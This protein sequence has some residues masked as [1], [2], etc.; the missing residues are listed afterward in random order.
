VRVL[1]DTAF[2]VRLCWVLALFAL[3]LL[4]LVWRL[5][6][7]QWLQRDFLLEEGKNRSIRYQSIPA[8]RGMIVDRNGVPLAVSSVLI[9]LQ[10]GIDLWAEPRPLKKDEKRRLRNLAKVLGYEPDAF[11]QRVE[12]EG[13]RARWAELA[14][15]LGEPVEVLRRRLENVGQAN[16]VDGETEQDF[17]QRV[18]NVGTRNAYP[19]VRRLAPE[20]AKAVLALKIPGIV[21]KEEYRRYYP[22]GEM[23]TQLIGRINHQQQAKEGLELMFDS[24]LSG[25]EGKRR[26][27]QDKNGRL[28]KELEVVQ[29]A[30]PGKDLQLSIDMRLQ[31]LANHALVG[32]LERSKASWGTAVL[33]DVATGEILALANQPT[34]NPNDPKSYQPGPARNHALLDNLQP[35][36]TVKPLSML[37]ALQSGRWKPEDTV[38]L[39]NRTLMVKGRK[40]PIRDVAIGGPNQPNLTQILIESSNVG[41]SKIALDIGP[42]PIREVM[43]QMGFGQ[44]SGLEFPREQV[45]ML[46]GHK[47]WGQAQTTNL[48][49]GY[50][51]EVTAVQLA[52]AYATIANMGNKKPL[53]LLRRDELPEGE[54]VIDKYSAQTVRGMLQ[55]V[56]HASRSRSLARVEGYQVAGKSGTVDKTEEGKEGKTR[57]LFAGFAPADKPRFALVIVLDEPAKIAGQRTAHYGGAVAAPV[58]SQVMEGALRLMQVPPDNLPAILA[59]GLR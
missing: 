38:D 20:Q 44:A 3:A 22:S 42:L 33:V 16:R 29:A 1:K 59:G 9:H 53:T 6:D 4:V 18:N 58:F 11:V 48:A 49:Y 39:G 17:K 19:L 54:Q 32:A 43:H 21:A 7:L 23:T 55:Q 8:P 45:G 27:L 12:K 57:A 14:N 50:G 40:A 37:A 2:P 41:I 15:A 31:T 10:A 52:Q 51:L 46:P 34:Y 28:L 24:W 5:V 47:R 36:S 35:G 26:V 56:V 13:S 30:Q 25:T